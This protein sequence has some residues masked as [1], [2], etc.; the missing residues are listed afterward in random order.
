MRGTTDSV[1]GKSHGMYTLALVKMAACHTIASFPPDD[2][3]SQR[4]I[5]WLLFE[6]SLFPPVELAPGSTFLF[7]MSWI[8]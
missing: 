5:T 6:T 1:V 8:L 3:I 2:V 7:L 4:Q